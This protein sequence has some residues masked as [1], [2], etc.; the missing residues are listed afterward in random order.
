MK[1][2]QELYG[3][4]IMH[5]HLDD[6]DITKALTL[7]K[8]IENNTIDKAVLKGKLLYICRKLNVPYTELVEG[9]LKTQSF[10]GTPTQELIRTAK[11][12]IVATIM[13]ELGLEEE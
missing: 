9:R 12:D 7:L 1:E 11:A 13:K 3:Y 8:T 5:K 6:S 2:I 10:L 4:L